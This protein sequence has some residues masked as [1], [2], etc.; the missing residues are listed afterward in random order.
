MFRIDRN[1]VHLSA[2]RFVQV[3]NGDTEADA[4]G[5]QLLDAAASAASAAQALI[6]AREMVED[7]AEKA[8][9]II[10]DARDEAAMLMLSAR[11]QAEE[12]RRRAWQEGFAEGSEE[13]KRAF[14][15]ELSA[16]LREDDE[17]LRRIIGEL[18]D[19]RKRTYDG[20]EDEVVALALDIAR[21]VINQPEEG[22]GG[23]FEALV[24]NALERM[25]PEEKIIIR[26]GCAEYE[27]FFPSGS[28]VMKLD[29]GVTVTASVMRDVSLGAGDCIMDT[30][31]A[32]INAG[33]DTQLNY[34]RL[35]F[36][37]AK[38]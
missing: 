27:R 15:E 9:R 11:D 20:L 30:E 28:A 18:Y 4:A 6:A 21:K 24:K 3:S 25:I 16:K 32:T 14:D 38:V 8:A 36:E 29:S 19:E 31:E 7:A 10:A 34:I 33:L 17:S 37:Q 13:G 26:V 22:P 12:D 5:E 2:T 1:Y 35:A 23:F